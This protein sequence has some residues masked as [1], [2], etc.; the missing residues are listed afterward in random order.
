MLGA[1]SQAVDIRFE[2]IET[3]PQV[4]DDRHYWQSYCNRVGIAA[5]DERGAAMIFL[6]PDVVIAD[7]GIRA[8]ASLLARGK[9]AIQVLGIRLVKE[10]VIPALLEGYS[11]LDRAALTI[12]P[13]QLIAL[14]MDN[15]HP[16]TMTHVYDAPDHDLTPTILMWRAGAEGLVARCF[17][18]HPMLVHPRVRN[19]PF[20]TTIDDDY[21]RAA[22][23]DPKDEYIVMDWDEFCACELSGL[24][25]PANSQ[26][27]T[28]DIAAWAA[29][30]VRPQHFDNFARRIILHAERTDEA[31]WNRACAASDQTVN[32]ILQ[33]VL[34]IRSGEQ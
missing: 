31:A 29:A 32:G 21:L 26:G 5:A 11:S 13:R 24:D 18:L 34:D 1:L 12:S 30:A 27:R 16:M 9:R 7:G 6:N 22:C 15:L 23:P 2:N 3:D 8:L 25:R 14:A 19:A 10:T 4:S 17:H 28:M 20:S 33:R